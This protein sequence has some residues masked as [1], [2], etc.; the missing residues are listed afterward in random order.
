MRM[1][2]LIAVAVALAL[3]VPFMPSASGATEEQVAAALFRKINNKRQKAH[4]LPRTQEWA[5]IVQEATEHSEYQARQGRIS[6]DGFNGRANRI[7]NAGTGINGVCENV[8]FVSGVNDLKTIVR[9]IYRG[10][11]R[12]PGHHGCMFDENFRTTWA[13]VGIAHDGSSTWYATYLG[14]QDASPGQP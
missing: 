2:A 4:D 12:S 8:A 9:T 7:Q 14:A 1:K 3:C 11:D 10:W 5:V 6:H 13:G